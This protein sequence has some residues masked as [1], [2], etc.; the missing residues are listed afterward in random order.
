M[1]TNMTISVLKSNIFWREWG[2]MCALA[3]FVTIITKVHSVN[4]IWAKKQWLCFNGCF[5]LQH[6]FFGNKS[7][8]L[9]I[10]ITY[11]KTKIWIQH[12]MWFK[13]PIWQQEW[14]FLL[15]DPPKNLSIYHSQQR[16]LGQLLSV[17]A[18]PVAASLALAAVPATRVL[19]E[20]TNSPQ[21]KSGG[22]SQRGEHWPAC[23]FDVNT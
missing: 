22:F 14:I 5:N 15:W 9:E 17:L 13:W 19:V 12:L 16:K 10:T 18:G 20:A 21:R 7:H 4:V 8:F 1:T 11:F 3:G 23:Y 2:V 6:N